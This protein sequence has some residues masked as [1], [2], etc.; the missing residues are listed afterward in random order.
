MDEHN[1]VY[2]AGHSL[3]IHN[4]ETKTQ[5]FISGAAESEC[6]TAL[7][8][9]PSGK[10]L[11]VAEKSEKGV[12]TVYDLS[13]LKRRKVLSLSD[14]SSKVHVP[15]SSLPLMLS[16]MSSLASKHV[17]TACASWHS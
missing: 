8:V 11:A 4:L 16:L 14:S 9:A 17:K 15:F 12:V 1:V 7:A 5:R 6:I 2:I 10:H 3:I 13:T